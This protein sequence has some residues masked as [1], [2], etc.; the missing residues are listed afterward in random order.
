MASHANSQSKQTENGQW[1]QALTQLVRNIRELA[2]L[3][4]ALAIAFAFAA[5]GTQL[6]LP[7]TYKSTAELLI[8]PRGL[9]VFDNELVTGQY[10]ANAAVNYVESQIH[11]ILSNRVLSQAWRSLQKLDA[12]PELQADQVQ[13]TS[14]DV[15]AL[16]RNITVAR[17]ER[18]YLLAVT[19]EGRTPEDAANRAN[20]VVQAYLA[21]ES[22]SRA[23]VAQRITDELGSRLQQLRDRLA[24]S[25]RR[26]EEYRQQK[27]LVS[28]ADNTLVVDQRLASAITTLSDVENRLTIMRARHQQILTGDLSTVV[29]LAE[30]TEQARLNLLAN[31]R[32]AAREE[33]AE[34]SRQLGSRHP[35]LQTSRS[36]V[37]EVDALLEAEFAQIRRSSET[38]LSQL[39]Q[40]RDDQAA[41]VEQLTRDSAASR[42]SLIELRA[43]DAQVESDRRL[44]LSFETRSR[45]IG[46]FARIDSANVRILSDATQ[47]ELR[48]GLFKLLALAIV[49]AIVGAMTGIAWAVVRTT[50]NP[51][52]PDWDM[53]VEPMPSP[54]E[55]QM[56][57][58]R[59]SLMRALTSLSS[60]A[61][62]AVTG[63]MSSA[64]RYNE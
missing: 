15:N 39:Q 11:V 17:A 2:F 14:A 48:Q 21:E 22:A 57:S 10:D 41:V 58:R 24:A 37:E 9:Q 29:A 61:T 36:K 5:V 4:V 40:E 18:S 42:E 51:A 34:L 12:G 56:A 50:I 33:L 60:G 8:D 7:R 47:P 26:S 53:P 3:I 28:T 38:V 45:E 43:L 23:V 1:Q 16:K 52:P 59:P 55:N 64:K 35:A 32:I 44:L 13:A 6:L 49:G 46:E 27:N 54:V 25:E 63:H 30:T 31:R 19:A 20:A 62:P